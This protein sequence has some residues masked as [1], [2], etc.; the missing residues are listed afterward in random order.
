M[1]CAM[2]LA[3]LRRE[4]EDRGID[5]G[6]VAPDPI[7]QVRLWLADAQAVGVFEANAM[8]LSTADPEGRP[9]GRFVLLKGLDERGFAFFTNFESAKARDLD[10][11]GLAALT[12]GWL[13]LHRQVRVQ[14]SVERLSDEESDAYFASRPQGAQIGAW[15]SPQSHVLEDR[16]ELDRHVGEI[17]A[18]FREDEVPRPPFWGGYLVR[19]DTIEL[20]QGRANRLHDRLRYRREDEDWVIE[21]LAP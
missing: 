20:W 6:D 21:R 15:A 3:H 4:Y 2:D 11:V 1:L 18:R 9:S 7:A 5:A 17:L 10:Q 8:V 13:E 16:A 19:P 14:G 12:F